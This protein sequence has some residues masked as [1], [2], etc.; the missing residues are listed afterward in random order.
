MADNTANTT[1]KSPRWL[2]G[3]LFI[4]PFILVA[5][6]ISAWPQFIISGSTTTLK[7]SWLL[8]GVLGTN[9]EIRLLFIVAVAGALGSSIQT[10]KSYA[11]HVAAGRF[12]A[13]FISW[14]FMRFP[15][16]I[17]LALL[18]YLV[19]RGGF[20]TGSFSASADVAT[21]V[22]PFGIAA[23]SA[24]TG[25]FAREAS[26]KLSE[27]FSNTFSGDDDDDKPA[28]TVA[29]NNLKVPLRASGDALKHEITGKGFQS[30]V[31]AAVD[32][33]KRTVVSATDTKV[34]VALDA[35][36]V[37]AAGTRKLTLRNPGGKPVTV[38]IEVTAAAAPPTI[39]APTIT[40]A[41][42]LKDTTS[43]NGTLTVDGTNFDAKTVVL[44]G[45]KE[46]QPQSPATP[47]KLVAQI[48]ATDMGAAKTIK[49]KV[50]NEGGTSAEK[51]VTIS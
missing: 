10:A 7:P 21:N 32:G 48:A 44:I 51:S 29:T 13:N 4:V 23:I 15:V 25:M 39:A 17:G 49:F 26:A 8:R 40:A 24:L 31:E 46:V 28:P 1:T 22:N 6:F 33:E 36:D 41:T 16:G 30:N 2:A 45:T 27:V 43:G 42:C 3:I 47:A 9:L 11:G 38:T 5:L 18:V 37:A 50:R 34:T 12:N 35:K 20:L 14:Y 19:I